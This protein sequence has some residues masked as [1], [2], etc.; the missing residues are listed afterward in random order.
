MA[1]IEHLNATEIR[2]ARET[3]VGSGVASGSWVAPGF[4]A[5]AVTR[6]FTTSAERRDVFRQLTRRDVICQAWSFMTSHEI[7]VDFFRWILEPHLTDRGGGVW[8][9]DPEAEGVSFIMEATSEAGDISAYFGCVIVEAQILF[10]ESKI[11]RL[12][13]TWSALHR[14]VLDSPLAGSTALPWPL[15]LIPTM[16]ADFAATV[17]AWG[18]DPRVDDVQTCH[19]GQVFLTRKIEPC[20]YG[21]DGRPE[22][23]TRQ[24][25]DVLAEIYLP[26]TPGLTDTAFGE[27]WT[28]RFALWIGAGDEHIRINQ[29]SGFIS[30]EDLKGYDWRVR[31]IAMQALTDQVRGLIEY[32]R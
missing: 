24:P 1:R 18:A 25:W 14:E 4:T 20:N 30:E 13:L 10:E 23:Y 27:D 8:T 15:V 12:E 2:L 26:E 7:G 22:A 9:L 17:D 16:T 31:R 32:R 3:A 21:P 19:G 11:L 5:A 6:G 29:A 28:G